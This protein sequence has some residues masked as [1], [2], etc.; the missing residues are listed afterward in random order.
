MSCKYKY[1][2]SAKYIQGQGQGHKNITF[3]IVCVSARTNLLGYGPAPSAQA[4]DWNKLALKIEVSPSIL[5]N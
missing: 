4:A 5:H 2:T 1:I 3:L